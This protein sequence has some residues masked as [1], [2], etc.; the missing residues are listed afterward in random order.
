MGSLAFKKLRALGCEFINFEQDMGIAGLK[1][2]KR[3]WRPVKYLKKY[4]IKKI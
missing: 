2:A 4:T 3:L 1:Q